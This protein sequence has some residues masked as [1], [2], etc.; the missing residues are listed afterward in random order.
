MRGRNRTATGRA[1]CR[2]EP[3]ETPSGPGG[4]LPRNLARLELRRIP[5]L[6]VRRM[7]RVAAR[8]VAAF[9]PLP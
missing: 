8:C 6:N 9:R 4:L 7:Y 3:R 2:S 1:V 5:E